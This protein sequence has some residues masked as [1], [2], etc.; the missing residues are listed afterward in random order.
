MVVLHVFRRDFLLSG[1]TDT[2]AQND[3]TKGKGKA[4][5]SD[6]DMADDA[7]DDGEDDDDEEEQSSDEEEE[8]SVA[9][10]HAL[11]VFPHIL[12]RLSPHRR[13]L[14]RRLILPP[15]SLVAVAPAVL[16]STIL[17]RKP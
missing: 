11:R 16:K 17:L 9:S 15:S 14:S 3:S 2:T 4:P 8:V 7:E 1:A 6:V 13:T 10:I 5:V 12:T